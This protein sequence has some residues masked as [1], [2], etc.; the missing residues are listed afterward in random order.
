MATITAPA[1]VVSA[2]YLA[3]RRIDLAIPV[4]VLAAYPRLVSLG[5]ALVVG[6]AIGIIV[7]TIDARRRLTAV[8]RVVLPLFPSALMRRVVAV[9]HR[10]DVDAVLVDAAVVLRRGEE[11]AAGQKR[12]AQK[13]GSNRPHIT[14]TPGAAKPLIADTAACRGRYSY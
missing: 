1:A 5:I 4:A 14:S 6:S 8:P 9:L 3:V 10:T 2:I 13:H 12:G 7:R 11:R